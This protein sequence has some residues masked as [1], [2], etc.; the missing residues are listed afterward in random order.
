MDFGMCSGVGYGSNAPGILRGDCSVGLHLYKVPRVVK[1]IVKESR[2]VISKCALISCGNTKITTSCWTT[3][4]KTMFEPKKRYPMSKDKGEAATRWQE[5]R[6]HVKIKSH[7]CWVGDWRPRIPKKFS[8]CKGS[9][10]HIRLP[11][12]GIWQRDGNPQGI[13]LWRTAGFDD[14]T[15]TG[16]VKTEMLVGHKQSNVRTRTQEKGAV[17]P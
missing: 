14:R 11:N 5:G 4:D 7:T 10:P 13:R 16:V 1:F 17:T 9:M 6:N 3:T 15:F 8:H 2:M 12:L